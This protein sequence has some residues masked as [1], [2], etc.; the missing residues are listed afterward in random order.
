MIT[1]YHNNRCTKSRC[2]LEELEKS[3]KDFEVVYYLETPPN[4][5]ELEEI[6]RKL[7][8][9][10]LELIRKG[11]KV[12]IENYKGKTL[13]DEEWVEAMITHPIL[14]ERPIIVSGD[15]AVIAR[16]TEKIKE[17]LG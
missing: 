14:I 7:G 5:S 6:I 10:P 1:I 8:I 2:A 17:I 12:F 4:K 3:G 13:T 9:K 16:P 15:Q 11:E